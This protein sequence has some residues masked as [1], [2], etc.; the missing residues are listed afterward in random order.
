MHP[1]NT[2]KLIFRHCTA[3]QVQMIDN[4]RRTRNARGAS[5]V[6]TSSPRSASTAH[7]TAQWRHGPGIRACFAHPVCVAFGLPPVVHKY[8]P[9]AYT[10]PTARASLAREASPS[11]GWAEGRRPRCLLVDD[12]RTKKR[13]CQNSI[14]QL[15]APNRCDR[16]TKTRTHYVCTRIL[17]IHCI[18]HTT[19]YISLLLYSKTSIT[20]AIVGH[21]SNLSCWSKSR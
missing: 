15:N 13:G 11:R 5:T 17:Y 3:V 21:R 1:T 19:Y 14:Q 18:L 4:A 7:S 12:S 10:G 9:D 2:H 20:H 6:T 16:Q 8:T